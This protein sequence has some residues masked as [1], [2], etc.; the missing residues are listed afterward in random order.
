[1]SPASAA[2]PVDA[3]PHAVNLAVFQRFNLAWG[4]HDMQALMACVTDDFVY[5][6][7]V[8]SEPGQTFS[9]REAARQ[10]VSSM[11]AHDAGSQ[12]QTLEVVLLGD[13]GCVRWAYRWPDAGKGARV[14]LGCDLLEFR[15]GLLARK[16]AYRKVGARPAQDQGGVDGDQK[17]L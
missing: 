12:A 16:D 17:P 1:M 2:K 10:G 14:E 4:A 11:W 7:S 6:A 9:G 5:A 3:S 15:G 8:G 13:R